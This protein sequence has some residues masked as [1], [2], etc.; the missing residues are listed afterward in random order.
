MS[1]LHDALAAREAARQAARP[2][3]WKPRPG[4]VIEGEVTEVGTGTTQYGAREYFR[5]RTPS[6]VI[7][8]W[9]TKGIS[10]EIEGQPRLT[11][12]ERLAV[13]FVGPERT[14]AGRRYNRF[15]L[16]RGG[17]GANKKEEK[18]EK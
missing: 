11:V 8:I 6:G 13:K 9:V 16:V 10:D 18:N 17:T 3:A 4:D 5:V 14:R 15:L 7:H 12:G 2:P 1:D